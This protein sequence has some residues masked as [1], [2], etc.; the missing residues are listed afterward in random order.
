[1]K[2]ILNTI[3]DL[4]TN[5]LQADILLVYVVVGCA[6]CK[7]FYI[8]ANQ[9]PIYNFISQLRLETFLKKHGYVKIAECKI[10]LA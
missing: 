5:E 10:W 3:V 6:K 2:L 7:L 8:K 1:V 4:K 9:R